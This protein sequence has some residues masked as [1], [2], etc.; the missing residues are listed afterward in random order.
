MPVPKTASV[1]WI[2]GLF[3]SLAAANAQ[4]APAPTAFDGTYPPVSWANANAMYTDRTG[5]TAPCPHRRPGPLHIANGEV[6]YTTASGYKLRGTVGPQG[7]LAMGLVAPGNAGNAGAQSLNLNTYLQLRFRLAKTIERNR[8]RLG[9]TVR[10]A[11]TP[12][13]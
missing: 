13:G 6:R 1:L 4:T 10:E 7:Q 8:K 11:N 3:G 12:F 9:R 2:L 5:R